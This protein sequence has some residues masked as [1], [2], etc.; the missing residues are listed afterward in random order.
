MAREERGFATP[1]RLACALSKIEISSPLTSSGCS[2]YPD[3]EDEQRA[4]VRSRYFASARTRR[5]R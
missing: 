4:S 3:P 5:D 2:C 1:L